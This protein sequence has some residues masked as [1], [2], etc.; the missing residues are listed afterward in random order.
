[1]HAY[2]VNLLIAQPELCGAGGRQVSKP[3]LVLNPVLLEIHT[4]IKPLFAAVWTRG[5][6]RRFVHVKKQHSKRG[7]YD[8]AHGQLT[9]PVQD[10][11]ISSP[12]R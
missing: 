1:M 4:A 5:E 7:G 10:A 9:D 2:Q 8:S 3:F 11:S 12:T 6:G